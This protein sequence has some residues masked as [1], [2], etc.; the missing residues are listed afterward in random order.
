MERFVRF[1]ARFLT[2]LCLTCLS[3]QALA[4]I[5]DVEPN[6]SCSAPQE[7]GPLDGGDPVVVTG[8]LDTPPDE[9]DVDFFRFEATPGADL[10]AELEGE[11]S[12]QGTLPDP[13]LG[14]FD[15]GCN[16]LDLNDD[17]HDSTL[18]SR[19]LLVAPADGVVI[20]A[21]TGFPDFDF[22]GAGESS[23]SYALSIAPAP[24]PI[25]SI[26]GRVI[27]ATTGEPLSGSSP[28]F[29]FVDL[30]RCDEFDCF[31]LVASEPTDEDGRFRFEHDFDGRPLRAG[32]YQVIAFA[33]EFEENAT[34]PFD[35]AG[36]EDVELGDLALA[37]QPISF[38][39][40]QPCE[41]LLPQGDSCRY[42]VTVRNNTDAPLE[43][44]AWSVVDGFGVASSL[45]FTRFEASTFRGFRQA[46]RA[47][48]AVEPSAHQALQFRFDVP[49]FALGAEYCTEIWLGVNP[50]PLVT[51]IR[52]AFLFCL[53]GTET[54][55]Q[56]MIEREG[57][58]VA[59]SLRA[60]SAAL[61][62]LAPAKP[63]KRR[64]Q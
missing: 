43:G 26:A 52:Q 12:G 32:T 9:P 41:D 49:A 50:E 55:F 1:G 25:G 40:I 63:G 53:I 29:A 47:P 30:L 45:G 39:D 54:G 15:S 58:E 11:S 62:G 57:Q 44:L 59:R 61:T 37:L 38:A 60:K 17:A 21:A 6:N 24:P 64:T 16:L 3:S 4:Q 13:L 7:V 5:A 20:L 14:L 2:V 35:V 51:T 33:N 56:V 18:D 34:A 42:S 22:T 8:S 31:E 46:V 48:V 36:G 10:I 28:P 27:D 19:L 23:G